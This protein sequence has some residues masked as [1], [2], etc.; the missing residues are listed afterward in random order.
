[1]PGE[2]SMAEHWAVTVERGGEKIVT[3]EANCLSGRDLSQ[4][5]EQTVRTAAH[6]LL[7]FIG[8]PAP[9]VED[10]TPEISAARFAAVSD[11]GETLSDS[12]YPERQHKLAPKE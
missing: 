5:D 1:M 8:D 4:E 2:T 10:A 3:I 12:W 9:K 7:A 11:G 6:H